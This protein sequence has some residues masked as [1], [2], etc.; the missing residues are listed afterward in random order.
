MKK[1]FTTVN[2]ILIYATTALLTLVL[3]ETGHFIV[4]RLWHFDAV[5]HPN[6]GSYSG[7][8]SNFQKIIIAAS[9]GP[10]ISLTQGLLS[11]FLLKRLTDKGVLSLFILW[12]SLHGLILFL[13]YLVCSP[14]FIYGDTGQVFQLL[15]FPFYVTIIIALASF[16]ILVKT[17]RKLSSNFEVYGQNI[18]SIKSR[19]NQLILFPLIIG[20]IFTL[21][22]QLPVPN[23]LLLF[24]GTTTPLIFLVA[25]EKLKDKNVDN[26]TVSID[27]LS[28]P[29]CILFAFTVVIVR[30]LI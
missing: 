14:F 1:D 24:A 19:L 9:L 10:L 18:I 16:F 2:S 26:P 8:A 6:D 17:V 23:L 29:V 30:V 3:H 22:L 5:M 4:E 7:V 28:I 20:G 27:K 12:F 13:G 11:L 21:L 25:Y 15:H